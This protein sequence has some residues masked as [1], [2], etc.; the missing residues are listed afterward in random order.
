M[1]KEKYSPYL[2]FNSFYMRLWLKCVDY[3]I[4]SLFYF[5]VSMNLSMLHP[6]MHSLVTINDYFKSITLKA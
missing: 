1:Y 2:I 4:L 6:K 3:L 5:N